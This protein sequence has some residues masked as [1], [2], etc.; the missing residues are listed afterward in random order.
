MLVFNC[1]KSATE[2]F[3]RT[4]TPPGN[5][6]RTGSFEQPSQQNSVVKADGIYQNTEGVSTT[7]YHWQ[8]HVIRVNRC[9][10]LVAMEIQT[11]YA[12]T[13][14][15]QAEGNAEIFMRRFI[16]RLLTNML[17][18]GKQLGVLTETDFEPMLQQ[19]TA[20]HGGCIFQQGTDRSVQNHINNVFWHLRKQTKQHGLPI[21]PLEAAWFDQFINRLIRKTKHRDKYFTPHEEM[22]LTWLADYYGFDD[23]QA[24]QIRRMLKQHATARPD[25]LLSQP[26]QPS[27][28]GTGEDQIMTAI[29]P[30]N[31]VSL[32]AF[33]RRKL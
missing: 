10:C 19:F 25:Q 33:R 26:Q 21:L 30:D 13:L 18:Y 24:E 8:I 2:F 27:S 3:T 7:P 5:N 14:V 22:I 23:H 32:A 16:D 20:Q 12:I 6:I 17:R 9:Y 15:N 29:Y 31:V 4:A 28:R 1:S 11:R